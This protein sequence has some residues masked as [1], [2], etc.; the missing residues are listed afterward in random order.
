MSWESISHYIFWVFFAFV[1]IVFIKVGA[2]KQWLIGTRDFFVMLWNAM[3]H[4]IEDKEAYDANAEQRKADEE[5]KKAMKEGK[6]GGKIGNE[7]EEPKDK[8]KKEQDEDCDKL[9]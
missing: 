3:V 6:G 9:Y 1:V 4:G 7:N 2:F 8:D 5:Y